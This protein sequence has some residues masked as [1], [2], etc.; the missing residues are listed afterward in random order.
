VPLGL[1]EDLL[2]D[3]KEGSR[4]KL[5][6]L[7]QK[8]NKFKNGGK[9][10]STIKKDQQG[11]FIKMLKEPEKFQRFYVVQFSKYTTFYAKVKK[12]WDPVERLPGATNETVHN[13]KRSKKR[14]SND[15]DE[16]D[17]WVSFRLA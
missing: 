5:K 1:F 16:S 14:R 7:A 3:P 17:R 6:L 9:K 11:E 8:F 13:G 4:N 15:L 10:T 2:D 12:P